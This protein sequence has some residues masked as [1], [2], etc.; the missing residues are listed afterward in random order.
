MY[1]VWRSGRGRPAGPNDE[2]GAVVGHFREKKTICGSCGV[3][4]TDAK[5][6]RSKET[7]RIAL[8][9]LC[10][11]LDE[12]NVSADLVAADAVVTEAFQKGH[13]EQFV[14]A[15]GTAVYQMIAD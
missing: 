9:H 4:D 11:I 2:T 6:S 1:R 12:N 3:I 7:T 14:D 10:S 5:D 15:I 13:T 8:Q